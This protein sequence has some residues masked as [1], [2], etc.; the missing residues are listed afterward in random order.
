MSIRAAILRVGLGLLIAAATCFND[1]VLHQSPLIGHFLPAGVV[2][3]VVL[4]AL[5][6]NPLLVRLGA[7]W[8]L[9]GRE[10]LLAAAVAMAACSFAGNGFFRWFA[11]NQAMP[12]HLV[13][14]QPD[15]QAAE[16]MSYVPAD[17]GVL[18]LDGR[19]DDEVVQ[20]LRIG[21][22]PGVSLAD[23]PWE[24][25]R[26]VILRWGGLALLLGLASICLAVIVHPQ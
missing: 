23:V 11:A 3:P 7:G 4:W 6:V 10:V 18:L 9:S 8:A 17:A 16:I 20:D 12:A 24:A 5:T 21:R 19:N 1:S 2:A 15:S 13:N 26:P 14:I 25:W 22:G